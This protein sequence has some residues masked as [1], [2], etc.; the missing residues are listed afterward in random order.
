MLIQNL[1]GRNE[2]IILHGLERKTKVS[3]YTGLRQYYIY[4]FKE[5][6]IIMFQRFGSKVSMY[7]MKSFAR[8]V[9]E[10]IM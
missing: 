1:L 6:K 5:K 9:T 7:Y 10:I 8:N 3:C 4:S 2:S